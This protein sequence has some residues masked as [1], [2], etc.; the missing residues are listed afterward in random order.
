MEEMMLDSLLNRTIPKI[1]ENI[2]FWMVRTQ[3]GAFYSEFYKD[4]FVAFGWNYIDKQTDLKDKT[5][6]DRVEAK[7]GMKQG[8]RAIKKCDLFMNSIQENDIILIPNRRLEE[9]I[10]A[11]A[12][13][14]YEEDECSIEDEKDVLWKLKNERHLLKEVKCPYKKRWKIDVLKTVKG[15]KLNYHLYKTLRNYNGIDD[16]DEHAAYI[17]SLIFDVFFYSDDL[18]IALRVNQQKD[19]GL[20]DLSGVL[21]GSLQYLSH[22]VEKEKIISKVSVCSE[23]DIIFVVKE[24]FDYVKEY[25]PTFVYTFLGLFGGTYGIIKLKEVPEFIKNIVTIKEK[26]KQEKIE[27]KMKQEELSSKELENEQKRIELEQK[28]LELSLALKRQSIN[29]L[30]TEAEAELIVQAR[31]PLNV[32]ADKFSPEDEVLTSA[33]V[34]ENI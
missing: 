28:K 33:I 9:I 10:I 22:F 26:Y 18:Y 8:N 3:G 5:L 15:D 31:E 11:V 21:Y 4:K 7:Y 23:G 27:T 32:S 13:E 19:I 1:K 14:Y 30:P 17:L 29:G 12:K 24:I 34:E 2:H 6:S 20:A 16:I 25:G